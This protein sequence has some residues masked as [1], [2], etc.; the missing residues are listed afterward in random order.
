MK[1]ILVKLSHFLIPCLI[2][3]STLFILG[4]LV[5]SQPFGHDESVYLTEARSWIDGSPADEFK[6]YRPIGMAGFGWIFLNFGDSEVFVRFFGVIFGAVALLFVHLLFKRMFNIFVALGITIT[7]GTST[8]FLQEAPLFQN[9]VPSSGLL[10][11]ILW[12][13]YIYY[14]SAG[15]SKVIY[16]V[17]PLAALAFYLRYGVVSALGIIGVLTL[18]VLVPKFIKK[19]GVD[20]SKLGTSLIISILLF[21]PHFIQSL[22]VEGKLLGI[23]SRSGEAAG[24]QYLGEGLLDYI[25]LLPNELG[26]WALGI[27]AIIGTIVTVVIIFRKNL[28]EN[29]AGLLWIG[30]IGLLNFIVTGLL[31]HAEARYVFFPMVLL[32]GTGIASLYYLMRNWPKAFINSLI[33]IFLLGVMFYGV[34]SYQEINSFF[35]TKEMDLYSVAYVKASEAIRYDSTDNNGCAIWAIPTNRPRVSWY[36][37]CNTLKINNAATFKKDFRIHLRK[38]HYSI[39]R[40]TLKE[41]QINQDVA[42]EFDIILTEIFRTENLSKLYGGDLIVY[43]VTRKNSD[44]ED[45]LNLLEK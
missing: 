40:A 30:S 25:R 36:S 15:K 4:S 31:V 24:R 1:K 3:G 18:L 20:Y 35:R 12:L 22:V 41:P 34:N 9:D 6:I 14:E 8:L 2:L 42:V 10:I 5:S 29:Y 38:D 32:S 11:G 27:T 39:V 13:L 21:V 28:R 45:Y 44:E 23:L 7:V 19:E 16:F 26:G 43:R 33:A 17:G 37:K